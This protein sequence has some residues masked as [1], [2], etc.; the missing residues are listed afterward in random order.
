MNIYSSASVTR[1][2]QEG[3]TLVLYMLGLVVIVGMAGL[4]LDM[5]HAYIN[6]S[7]LQNA[8]DAAALSGAK[9]LNDTQDVSQADTTALATF[10]S[11]MNVAGLTPTVEYSSTLDPFVPGSVNPRYIRVKL[12]QQQFAPWFAEVLPGVGNTLT[13]GGSAV[14]GPSAPLGTDPGSQVCDIAPMMVCGDPTA[15]SCTSDG[16]YGYTYGQEIVLKAGSQTNDAVG[17]GNYQLIQLDCGAGGACVRD[18]LAGAYGGCLTNDTSVTTK[19]G[20]T[21]G[22]TAQGFNTR[23]GIYNG[24]V[25]QADYPPDVVTTHPYT[26]GPYQ[27]RLKN[28][29]YDYS[30]VP[31]G[32]GV[33]Q[34]RVM[35]V[36]FGDCSGTTNGQGDVTVMGFGC[37]FLTKPAQMGGDQQVYGEFVG[38]CKAA[39]TA[40]ENPPSESTVGSALYKII[41]YKDPDSTDS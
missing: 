35:A 13:V 21:V 5:G 41:L 37:F 11:N 4:A 31:T 32:I 15:T 20:D 10:A 6:K 27:D 22:P 30:P 26:Y 16:C 24:P 29:P 9:I 25:S 19:P 3:A 12:S 23:F 38:D 8:L 39:G 33:P 17:P 28:G 36:P 1:H 18:N 34:R 14:A 7:K 40:S 2:K